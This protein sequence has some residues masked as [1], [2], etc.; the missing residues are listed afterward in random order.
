MKFAIFAA[1]LTSASAFMA[2][3]PASTAHKG[4]VALEAAVSPTIN[5]EC[6]CMTC[7]KFD[8]TEVALVFGIERSREPFSKPAALF[9]GPFL[10]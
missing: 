1:L 7:A 4:V 6:K 3:T 8:G 9:P 2:G 5:G 10:D